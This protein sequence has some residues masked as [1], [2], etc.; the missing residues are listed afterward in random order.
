MHPYQRQPLRTQVSRAV[1]EPGPAF[2]HAGKFYPYPRRRGRTGRIK[3]DPDPER[4]SDVVPPSARV[5]KPPLTSRRRRRRVRRLAHR[6]RI[7]R[8]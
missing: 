5:V 6:A 3:F 1:R 2:R 7:A 8:R 4:L